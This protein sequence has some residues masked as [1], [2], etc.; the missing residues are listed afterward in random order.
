MAHLLIGTTNPVR[1]RRVGWRGGHGALQVVGIAH[2]RLFENAQRGTKAA[3]RDLGRPPRP[4]HPK[5]HA[6]VELAEAGVG[7]VVI[8]RPAIPRHAGGEAHAIARGPNRG[9]E[10]IGALRTQRQRALPTIAERIER[11]LTVRTSGIGHRRVV[12]AHHPA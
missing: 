11:N 9:Q 4:R 10:Q 6:A 2:V 5:R 12:N 8:R 1:E 7:Q 3:K